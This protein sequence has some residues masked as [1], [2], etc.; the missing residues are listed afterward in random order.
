MYNIKL[1]ENAKVFLVEIFEIPSKN[2]LITL[3]Y[4][5]FIFE[6]RNISK[7]DSKHIIMIH[8][9]NTKLYE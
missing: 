3:H 7:R 4:F 1:L 9:P 5:A 2:R 6:K 8:C